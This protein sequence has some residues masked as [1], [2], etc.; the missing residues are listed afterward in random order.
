MNLRRLKEAGVDTVILRVFQNYG[1]R[2]L[3][4]ERRKEG[5]GLY[6]RTTAGPVLTDYLAAV[7]PVCRRLGLSVFAWITTRRCEWLLNAEPELAEL[8]YDPAA[9]RIVRSRSLSIFQPR[10]KERLLQLGLV[11][12]ILLFASVLLFDI[13]K[14]VP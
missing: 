7:I 6:F 3:L 4:L 5:S 10:V 9:G 11:L 12:L 1:D 8:A 14:F 13:L 2:S